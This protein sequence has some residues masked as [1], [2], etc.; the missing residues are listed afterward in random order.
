MRFGLRQRLAVLVL[1]IIVPLLATLAFNVYRLFSELEAEQVVIHARDARIIAAGL[2][3]YVQQLAEVSRT[4]GIA[5]ADERLTGPRAASY[6]AAVARQVGISRAV[7]LSE[8]GRLLAASGPGAEASYGSEPAFRSVSSGAESAVSDVRAEADGRLRFLVFTRVLDSEGRVGGVSAVAVETAALADVVPA[9]VTHGTVVITDSSGTLVYSSVPTLTTDSLDAR[10]AWRG[11]GVSVALG[12]RDYTSPSTAIPGLP[13]RWLGAVVPAPGIDWSVGLFEP[14]GT[15]MGQ[16]ASQ[17]TLDVVVIAVLLTVSLIAALRYGRTITDPVE[18]LRAATA[19]IGDGRFDTEI[20]EATHDEIGDLAESFR[21]MR[22]SLKHTLSDVTLLAESARL[23]SSTL[24]FNAVAQAAS[25]YLARI[26]GARA[27]VISLFGEGS[28]ERTR[29]LAPGLDR[30]SAEMLA[31]AGDAATVGMDLATQGYAVLDVPPD[32]GLGPIAPDARHLVTLPLVVNRRVIGRL[33]A[34]AAPDG[35]FESADMPLVESLAQQVAV[36]VENARLFEQQRAIADTLQDALLTKPY[37]I[38]G[39]E[40]GL[41]Y[42]QATVGGRIG[43]DFYDFIPVSRDR[44]VVAIGDITGK[45]LDAARY[46][47]IGK[48]AIRNFALDDPDPASVL[49]RANRVIAEQLGP[50]DFI[51]AAC[52]L[53]DQATGELTFS[54]AGHPPPILLDADSATARALE[55]GGLPLGIDA[56]E[57]YAD[58]HVTLAPGD[59]LLLYTDG[60]SEARRGK[61]LFGI[62]RVVEAFGGFRGVPVGDVA[63]GIAEAAIAFAGGGL[64]DDLAVVVLER[65]AKS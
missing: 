37:R 26:V 30:G 40:V 46:T 31:A 21:T 33:D 13:G 51:T 55:G 24:D 58:E 43:G 36:A 10:R 48:G 14:S 35:G 59:R 64:S 42:Y 56:A 6:L 22:D 3:R 19:E 45:G 65:S 47:A 39:L 38:A 32:A 1:V 25:D 44:T 23:V 7:F 8:D 49:S 27:V 52:V 20:P 41:V 62:D 60:L 57:E 2:D 4:S 53:L 11:P 54:V 63:T 28:G 29:L 50:E 5:V 17:A 12:G 16:V 9:S 34:L 18:R 61:E 15:A